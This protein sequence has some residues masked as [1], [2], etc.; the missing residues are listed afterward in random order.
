MSLWNGLRALV[1]LRRGVRALERIADA[2][3]ELAEIERARHD[4]ETM[5][6]RPRATEFGSFDVEESNARWRKEQEAREYGQIP[7]DAA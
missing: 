4:R 7:E 6:R 3:Q 2:Q 5:K 1:F